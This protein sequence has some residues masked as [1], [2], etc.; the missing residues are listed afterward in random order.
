MRD[1]LS[2]IWLFDR[3]DLDL[4]E[5][6]AVAVALVAGAVLLAIFDDEDRRSAADLGD[7]AGDLSL[8]DIGGADRGI[9]AVI[10]E[11]DLVEDDLVALFVLARE[12]LDGDDVPFRD[13]ILLAA[14][15]D[16]CEFH[17]GIL[18][19]KAPGNAI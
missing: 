4:E 16:D 1:F 5:R 6:L 15:G 17:R 3:V 10:H 9:L 11:Q 19:R 7:R 13:R 14:C 18:Y 8:G 12:L 2:L